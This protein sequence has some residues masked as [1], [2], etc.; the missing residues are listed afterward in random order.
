MES[1]HGCCST[2]TCISQSNH[3]CKTARTCE[4]LQ[5]NHR[6][7]KIRSARPCVTMM[8][9]VSFGNRPADL[10]TDMV[11][12]LVKVCSGSVT[13]QFGSSHSLVCV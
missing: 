4:T 11:S 2:C 8:M 10:A 5:W 6:I 13:V 1:W 9:I 7:R 12:T 3:T